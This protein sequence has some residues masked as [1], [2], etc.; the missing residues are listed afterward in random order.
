MS[1][2][3]EETRTT[4]ESGQ[5]YATGVETLHDSELSLLNPGKLS[6]RPS[7]VISHRGLHSRDDYRLRKASSL[8]SAFLSD[9]FVVVVTLFAPA[10]HHSRTLT[11]FCP[12][13][14]IA[15]KSHE[16]SS[17]L[18]VLSYSPKELRQAVKLTYR[19][20]ACRH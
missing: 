7:V 16:A 19:Q 14:N 5:A 13:H 17:R 12:K 11:P 1:V 4:E 6:S 2:K 9:S 8:F 15:S 3:L 18:G 20:H 10:S